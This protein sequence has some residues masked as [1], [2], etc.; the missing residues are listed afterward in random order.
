MKRKQ[1]MFPMPETG[2][3]ETPNVETTPNR[4][5]VQETKGNFYFAFQQSTCIEIWEE[6]LV[7]LRE[8]LY[9]RKY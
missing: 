9:S 8:N 2:G 7:E 5:R 4:A 1:K 6:T 3:R